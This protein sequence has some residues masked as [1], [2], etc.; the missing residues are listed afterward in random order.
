[1]RTTMADVAQRAGTSVST[2]SLVLNNKPGVSPEM[3]VAVL[4]AAAE[5]GYS[6]PHRRSARETSASVTAG[7]CAA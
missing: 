3:R 5:L 7:W 4:E 2:V 1:M 6:L